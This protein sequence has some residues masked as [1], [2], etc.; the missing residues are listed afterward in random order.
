MKKPPVFGLILAGGASSRLFPFNK[1]LSDITGSG[2][3]LIQ[4][5][6]DRLGLSRASTYVLT[7]R[8]MVAPI[9]K[10]LRFAPDHLFVDPVRRGTW[11]AILWAMAHLRR[12]NPEAVLAIVTAD[13]VIQGKSAFREAL[14][15]AVTL[16]AQHRTFVMLG[17]PPGKQIAEWRSFGCFR[18]D[19]EGMI[20][21]FEEK[22]S[23]ERAQAMM[24]EGGWA[25]NSGMFFFKLST[26]EQALAAY[27][28]DMHRVY[29]AIVSALEKK[30]EK[31]AAFLFEDFADKIP[32]A[33]DAS[34]RVDNSI[35]YAIMTPLTGRGHTELTARA[36]RNT[37]FSWT[38]LG[39]WDALR[40]VVKADR[41]GNIRIGR[42]TIGKGVEKCILVADKGYAITCSGARRLVVA[43]AQQTVIV[44]AEDKLPFIKDYVLE[45]RNHPDQNVMEHEVS[46][47]TAQ[48]SGGRLLLAGVS[49]LKIQLKGKKLSVQPRRD[50]SR[51]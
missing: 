26:A 47:C 33:L 14:Q 16:A 35:D 12:Q 37:G 32:H 51:R 45:A 3:T 46:E 38:D 39:Q 4:Q 15:K 8:E 9:Q 20:R 30:D 22:P 31:A 28:P 43:F 13:H 19:A 2:R 48:A 10:Q 41:K 11:P 17:I 25:W 23:L 34:R 6:F 24:D 44:M 18:A 50:A 49:G 36:I 5:S 29:L 27:Q 42:A 21:G 7:V 1:V 40:K